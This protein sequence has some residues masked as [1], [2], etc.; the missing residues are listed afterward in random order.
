MVSNN[1]QFLPRNFIN[2]VHFRRSYQHGIIDKIYDPGFRSFLKPYGR[3]VDRALLP[4]QGLILAHDTGSD[5]RTPNL[6]PVPPNIQPE[7][8]F[9]AD[10]EPAAGL[11]CDA[12]NAQVDDIHELVIIQPPDQAFLR[13]VETLMLTLILG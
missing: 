7:E 13:Y 6:E 5:Y 2:N 1:L 11:H 8:I 10:S 9:L 3:S 4:K 12:A